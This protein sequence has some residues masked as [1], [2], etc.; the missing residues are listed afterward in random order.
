MLKK[1]GD[2]LTAP[3]PIKLT[4]YTLVESHNDPGVPPYSWV[5]E[6]TLTTTG[7]YGSAYEVLDDYRY[8]CSVL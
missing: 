2:D 7:K 5:I 3:Q 4:V 6:K 1:K 8:L